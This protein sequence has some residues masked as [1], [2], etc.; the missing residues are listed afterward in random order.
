MIVPIIGNNFSN[1]WKTTR[2]STMARNL[3]LI[4][5]LAKTAE[6]ELETD[7]LE[8]PARYVFYDQIN[9]H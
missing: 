1:G 8:N 9:R 7:F 6:Q 2:G 3:L 5:V 4:S